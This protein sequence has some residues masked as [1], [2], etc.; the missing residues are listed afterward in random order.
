MKK[1]ILFVF[2]LISFC[3]VFAEDLPKA[4]RVE[5]SKSLSEQTKTTKLANGTEITEIEGS[6]FPSYEKNTA[7]LDIPLSGGINSF[8]LIINGFSSI[9]VT[10]CCLFC[11]LCIIFHCFKLW[12]AT[13]EMKKVFVDII[14]KC[15]ICIIV[16]ITF[17]PLTNKIITLATTLGTSASG[18]YEKVDQTYTTAY[19]TLL[20]AIEK[21]LD[22]IKNSIFTNA[23]EDTDGK[24][25]ISDKMLA[26]M[27]NYGMTPEE[28]EAWAKENGL[29]IAHEEFETS[30]RHDATYG[31][32]TST[33]WYDSNGNKIKQK[34][35]FFTT[36]VNFNRKDKK[37]NKTFDAE[38]QKQ[39][40]KKINALVEVLAG[41]NITEAD[42]AEKPEEHLT[43]AKER[44]VTVLKNLFYSPYLKNKNDKNTLFLSP[45]TILKTCTVMSDAVAFGSTDVMDEKTGEITPLTLNPKGEWTFKGL[46]KTVYAF[47][48]EF[49]MLLCSIIIMAEYTLTILEFYLIRGLATLLIPFFF[50][51][52]TKSYAEN[53]I[54]ILLTYFFKI[55]ITVFVCY[56]SLGMFLD[57]ASQTFSFADTSSTLTLITYISTL[58]MGVMLATKIPSIL[59]TLMSGNPS[60]GWGTIAETARGAA[61]GL[62]M[63]QHA[64]QSA[65]QVGSGLA[66]AGQAGVRAGMGAAATLDSMAS[67]YATTR[68][69]ISNFNAGLKPNEGAGISKG[70]SVWEGVKAAVGTGV[71][72]VGQN[73]G[74]TL[75]KGIT[76][77]EKQRDDSNRASL[78]YG[79][80]FV[81]NQGKTKKADFGDM[82]E[83]AKN[84]GEKAGQERANRQIENYK[85][86]T[87]PPDDQ[88]S[89][90]NK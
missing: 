5:L 9:V 58:L 41:E 38:Q 19:N 6:F 22:E 67:A 51:D 4:K 24:K 74:D 36:S 78:K 46:I 84:R 44:S 16:L 45:S 63:A 1:F 88:D 25:Y 54:R 83:H 56:F 14:Y 2:L 11:F 90:L 69:S 52:A 87:L 37:I 20:T 55:L 23:V 8:A 82:T 13:T 68:D 75:Y 65:K 62:H 28:A 70:R 42:L 21:G 50:L 18:G 61:H 80:D 57:V 10:L 77:Q 59:G 85:K 27:T 89:I 32:T 34:T 26:E 15:L 76:G 71:S 66:H 79:H 33:G 31:Q 86:K 47:I 3:S 60:M 39:Y 17:R 35:W 81:D 29:N 48:Y 30:T 49:G 12:F 7:I 73:V 40:I 72:S 43:S 53:I 64:V